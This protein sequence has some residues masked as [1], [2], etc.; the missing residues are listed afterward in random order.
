MTLATGIECEYSTKRG[1]ASPLSLLRFSGESISAPDAQNDAWPAIKPG[2]VCGAG[3]AVVG[4]L[5]EGIAVPNP[6]RMARKTPPAT[7]GRAAVVE[8]TGSAWFDVTCSLS[9]ISS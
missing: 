1:M 8:G 7:E 4:A 5:V 3:A 6:V 2:R 9:A